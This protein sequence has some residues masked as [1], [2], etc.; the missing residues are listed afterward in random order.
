MARGVSPSLRIG[1]VILKL[2]IL[3]A[4]RK[5]TSKALVSVTAAV[6]VS[7]EPLVT[8]VPDSLIRLGY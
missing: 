3:L 5:R 2:R 4:F 6:I 1:S 7:A 8:R